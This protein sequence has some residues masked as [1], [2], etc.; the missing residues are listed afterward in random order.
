MQMKISH[1]GDDQTWTDIAYRNSGKMLRKLRENTD[2]SA[3]LTDKISVFKTGQM[4][5]I[6]AETDG[7]FQCKSGWILCHI[8]YLLFDKRSFPDKKN[9]EYLCPT[10]SVKNL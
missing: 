8:I 10:S 5:G 6:C 9:T 3:I 1:S 7:A 2:T 4:P